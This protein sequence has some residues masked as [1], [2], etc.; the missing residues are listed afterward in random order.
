[1]VHWRHMTVGYIVILRFWSGRKGNLGGEKKEKQKHSKNYSK[2]QLTFIAI[3]VALLVW[4][5]W[6]LE[7]W[8]WHETLLH[9]LLTQRRRAERCTW[10]I[11]V[12]RPCRHQAHHTEIGRTNAIRIDDLYLLSFLHAQ[13]WASLCSCKVSDNPCRFDNSSLKWA[14]GKRKK[15]AGKWVG[16]FDNCINF[17]EIFSRNLIVR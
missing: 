17:N 5:R 9:D 7:N 2:L 1:M 13:L 11:V 3:T 16:S 14:I 12:G 10:H 6:R 15:Y 8:S 4:R